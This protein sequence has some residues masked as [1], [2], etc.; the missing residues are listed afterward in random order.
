MNKKIKILELEHW[1]FVFENALLINNKS[2]IHPSFE[3]QFIGAENLANESLKRFK[4]HIKKGKYHA[5]T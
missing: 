3:H 1:R 2:D 5:S 4:K